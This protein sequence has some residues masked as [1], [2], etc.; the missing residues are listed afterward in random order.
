MPKIPKDTE[1]RVSPT[2]QHRLQELIA[3]TETNNAGFANAVGISKDVITRAVIYGIIPAL[4][5]L[6]KIADYLNISIP[7][8]LAE[9]DEANFYKSETPQSFETRVKTLASEKGVT[10]SGIAA[11]MPFAKNSFAEW[12]KKGTLPSLEY[13]KALAEYFQVSVDYLLG[14]TD[15]K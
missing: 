8:L 13:L 2:F 11:V 12:F 6:I 5:S 15:D 7:Y 14:R 9:N 4:R 1:V 3:D 10:L